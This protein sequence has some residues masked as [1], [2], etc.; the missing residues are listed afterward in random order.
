MLFSC[1]PL[2]SHSSKALLPGY[3]ANMDTTCRCSLTVPWT[4]QGM[5]AAH[6]VSVI[7][8]FFLYK[9]YMSLLLVVLCNFNQ[10]IHSWVSSTSRRNWV[11]EHLQFSAK[12][13]NSWFSHWEPNLQLWQSLCCTEYEQWTEPQCLTVLLVPAAEILSAYLSK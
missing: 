4:A 5:K 7:F 10:I 2:Q 8:F 3:T 11:G 1:A 13:R 12:V 9:A 6:F